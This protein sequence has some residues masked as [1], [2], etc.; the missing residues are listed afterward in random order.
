MAKNLSFFRTTLAVAAVG[1]FATPALAVPEE[2]TVSRS[3]V[4]TVISRSVSYADLDMSKMADREILKS[5]VNRVA[6]QVCRDLDLHN[7]RGIMSFTSFHEPCVR[8]A[9]QD[10]LAQVPG[11]RFA[12]AYRFAGEWD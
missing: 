10:A 8:N 7:S 4:A 9:R 5:R 2:V 12:V 1:A 3:G 11:I 6:V